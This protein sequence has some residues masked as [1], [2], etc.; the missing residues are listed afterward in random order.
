MSW[1]PVLTG[2]GFSQVVRS[3]AALAAA[4]LAGSSTL[5]AQGFA[6]AERGAAALGS[7][8][9]QTGNTP[10]ADDWRDPTRG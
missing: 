5:G 4:L 2:R 1:W 3:A 8:I 6:S 7:T 9:K 10:R